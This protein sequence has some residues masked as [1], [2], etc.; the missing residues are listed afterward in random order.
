ML[1]DTK[2]EGER[3]AH[4]LGNH[5]VHLLRGH[6]CD[7]VAESLPRL[8]ASAIYLRDNATIELQSLQLGKEPKY[9]SNEEAKPAMET[10]LFGEMPLGRM[11]S[12]WTTR[13]KRAMPDIK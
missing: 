10:A 5:R 4:H 9:L 11:W 1:I 6:G 3:I 2:K 8:V 7:I 13:V 12:Y